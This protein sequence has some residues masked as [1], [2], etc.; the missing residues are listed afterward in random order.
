MSWF[1]FLRP[2]DGEM[3]ASNVVMALQRDIIDEAMLLA[4]IR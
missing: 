2:E 3:L 4:E 1:S